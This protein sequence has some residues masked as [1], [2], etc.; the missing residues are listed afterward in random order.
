MPWYDDLML[1][2]AGIPGGNGECVADGK[3]TS[4]ESMVCWAVFGL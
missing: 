1:T 3:N 2:G 4:G